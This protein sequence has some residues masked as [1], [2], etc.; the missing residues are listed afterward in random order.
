MQAIRALRALV[1]T[2]IALVTASVLAEFIA[3]DPLPAAVDE[4]LAGPGAGP[5]FSALQD[6]S[7][8]VLFGLLAVLFCAYI[9]ALVGLLLLKPWARRIYVIV[10]IAGVCLDPFFGTSLVSPLVGTIDYLAVACSGAILALLFFGD[11]RARF[12]H[13]D[14]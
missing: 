14:A 13:S 1:L 11:V 9:A 3:Q 5:L 12:E 4:Y 8:L 6:E 10:F 2:E 7:S